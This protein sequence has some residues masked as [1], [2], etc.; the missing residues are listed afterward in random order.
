MTIAGDIH[1]ESFRC[2]EGGRLNRA[3]NRVRQNE[4]G[5]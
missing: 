5:Y 1:D 2:G 3:P 4:P